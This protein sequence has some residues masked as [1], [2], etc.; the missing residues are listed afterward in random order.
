LKSQPLENKENA[1]RGEK[2]RGKTVNTGPFSGGAE[3]LSLRVYYTF[4]CKFESGYKLNMGKKEDQVENLGN[5][6]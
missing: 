1:K 3:S 6:T 5:P 4:F 2:G